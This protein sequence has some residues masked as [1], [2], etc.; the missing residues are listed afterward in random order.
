MCSGSTF[1]IRRLFN[2][3]EHGVGGDLK[4]FIQFP[5]HSPGK[6]IQNLSKMEY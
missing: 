2:F 6:K 4:I 1:Q 5:D 3:E